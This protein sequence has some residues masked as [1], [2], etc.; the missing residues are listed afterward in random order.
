LRKSA[1][2]KSIGFTHC[3]SP[4]FCV[5]LATEREN[6]DESRAFDNFIGIGRL[7]MEPATAIPSVRAVRP[8]AI[9]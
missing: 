3:S 1:T 6:Q 2:S 8:G 4:G 9:D 7:G 5:Q